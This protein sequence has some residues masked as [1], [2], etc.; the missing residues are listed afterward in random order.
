[1]Y[2]KISVHIDYT[3]GRIHNYVAG[4]N[5][6]FSAVITLKPVITLYYQLTGTDS[7]GTAGMYQITFNG[8]RAAVQIQVSTGNSEVIF[9]NN[10]PGKADIFFKDSVS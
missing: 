8:K 6:I 1:M 7:N 2:Y 3:A 4:R 10:I 9:N 5:A